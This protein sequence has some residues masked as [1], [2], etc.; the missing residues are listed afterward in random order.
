MGRSHLGGQAPRPQLTGANPSGLMA[1][2]WTGLRICAPRA[3]WPCRRGGSAV[4]R[5]P[6]RC[7]KGSRNFRSYRVVGRPQAVQFLQDCRR[8][9]SVPH[10]GQGSGVNQLGI[11]AVQR[12]RSLWHRSFATA[13][14]ISYYVGI[15]LLADGTVLWRV[16]GCDG[17]S[18]LSLKLR[19]TGARLDVAAANAATASRGCAQPAFRSWAIGLSALPAAGRMSA[20]ARLDP[21]NSRREQ[22]ASNRAP[23]ERHGRPPA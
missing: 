21:T 12:K 13:L 2:P 7:S 11:V 17:W 3:N 16:H 10:W 1:G 8:W 6:A 4:M 5:R 9:R 14:A 19:A 20:V 15:P 23:P 22:R 18:A